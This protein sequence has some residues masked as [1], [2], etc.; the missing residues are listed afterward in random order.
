MQWGVKTWFARLSLA[1]KLT[2]ISIVTAGG[3]LV[4]A[5]AVFFAYDFSTSRQ[6]LVRDMGMLADVIGRNST[7]TIA[8]GDVKTAGDTL[9]GISQ[10]EH[11]ISAM[12][13]T[14][15]GMPLAR[16]TRNPTPGL[17]DQTS[18]LPPEALKGQPWHAFIGR[19]LML[20]RPILQG[21]E[22]VGAVFIESDLREIWTRAAGLAQIVGA[23]L[24][25]TFWLALA[26]A[27]RLQRFISVPLL[28]LTEITRVVTHDRRYDVRAQKGGDDEIGELIDGFNKMLEEIQRRDLA[29]LGNQENLERTVEVRTAELRAANVDMIA[30]RDRA[31]EASRAKSEF[32][33]NMSHEIRTPMNGIIGMTDLA[34]GNAL[35]IQTRECLD[36]VK[37][38]AESL[39]GILNDIL[40]FSKIESR[41][42]ELELVPFALND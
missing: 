25:G 8:F 40:D 19:G 13:L 34:L 41:K 6:K 5:C 17:P 29:L 3:S 35:D 42:L 12:I 30:A 10:N 18:R 31:M 38:S 24:F 33:A 28:G 14:P 23:V 11:I 16:F 21:T 22:V 27:F 9:Q 32:L 20:T 37:M 15:E 36:T 39:L 1:R 4:L 2:A 7:A 26:V